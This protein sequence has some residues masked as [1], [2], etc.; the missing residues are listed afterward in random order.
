MFPNFIRL[1]WENQKT[2]FSMFLTFMDPNRVQIPET[3]RE[4]IFS[5]EQDFGEK[6]VQQ[7]SHEGQTSMAHTTRFLSRVGPAY[8][9][10]VAPM[11]LIFILMDS[12]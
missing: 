5:T 11:P 8:S 10:I 6:E 12:S 7:G 4:P 1:T 9:L 3:L 2:S